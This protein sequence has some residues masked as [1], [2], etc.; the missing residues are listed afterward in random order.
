M[1]K[2]KK[3]KIHMHIVLKKKNETKSNYEREI[4]IKCTLTP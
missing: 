3:K 4:H 1:E 2:R